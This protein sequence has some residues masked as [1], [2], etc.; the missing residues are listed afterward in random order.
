MCGGVVWA[1]FYFLTHEGVVQFCRFHRAVQ[2]ECARSLPLSKSWISERCGISRGYRAG[3][4]WL[5]GFLSGGW[6]VVQESDSAGGGHPD[7]GD[8]ESVSAGA[9]QE[10]QRYL[11]SEVAGSGGHS[12]SSRDARDPVTAGLQS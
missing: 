7:L 6:N 3:L 2:P 9:A 4:P 1:N 11:V 8:G 10:V 12:H 5:R